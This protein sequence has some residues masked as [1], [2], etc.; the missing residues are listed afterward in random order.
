M[1]SGMSS[2]NLAVHRKD[3]REAAHRPDHK[4]LLL[5]LR[6]FKGSLRILQPGNRK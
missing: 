4:G 2:E 5:F 1:P 3:W 6:C